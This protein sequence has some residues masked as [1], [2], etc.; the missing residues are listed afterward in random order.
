MKYAIRVEE[1]KGKT[2]IVE[3]NNVIE[4][5]E[6]MEN[7]DVDLED[8]ETEKKVIVSPYAKDE[9]GEATEDQVDLCEEYIRPEITKKMIE[10]GFKEGI[11]SI[12]DEYGGCISLCC[13]I[14]DEAFYFAGQE[15]ED[16]TAS[17][18]MSEFS[19]E[20]IVD[21]LY[22]VLRY[23]EN[24]KANGLDLS[25]WYYYHSILHQNEWLNG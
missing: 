8:E 19:Q 4:A 11:L 17:E 12:E 14:K 15:H 10:C 23:A 5:I 16:D 25:E 18:F 2:F 22:N 9:R 6:I 13:R 3:A 20:E 7:A 1:T 24:G 21:M